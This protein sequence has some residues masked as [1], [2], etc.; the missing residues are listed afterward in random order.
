MCFNHSSLFCVLDETSILWNPDIHPCVFWYQ[1][2]LMRLEVR[3]M[4]LKPSSY[5]SSIIFLQQRHRVSRSVNTG[6]SRDCKKQTEKGMITC[7][8]FQKQYP[9][10]PAKKKTKQKLIKPLILNRKPLWTA[11]AVWDTES[12]KLWLR[13]GVN[14]WQNLIC[15]K[16]WACCTRRA[17]ASRLS[18]WTIRT[19]RF[20]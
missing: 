17:L 6:C 8:G 18:P 1:S 14:T 12:Y 10:W 5:H 15:G 20:L 19:G 11:V 4:T 2:A 13:L 9:A 16:G 7:G 3:M